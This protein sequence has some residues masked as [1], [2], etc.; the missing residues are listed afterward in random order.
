MASCKSR[1]KPII[2]KFGIS[3]GEAL[4]LGVSVRVLFDGMIQGSFTGGKSHDSSDQSAE[5][6]VGARRIVNGNDKAKLI[7][8]YHK[9]FL[10]AIQAAQD[11]ERPADV[12]PADA[13]ADDVPAGQSG[14]VATTIGTAG[15][16]GLL[17]TLLTGLNNLYALAG[18]ALMPIAAFVAFMFWSG[19]WSVNRSKAVGSAKSLPSSA[20]GAG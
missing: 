2:K 4:D 5:E 19:R 16:G 15:G 12:K 8:G 10:D 1:T 17:V 9:N 6:P 20:E 14:T 3:K 11:E 7:A 13:K 18:F